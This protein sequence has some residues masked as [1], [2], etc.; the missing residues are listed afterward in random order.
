MLS[1]SNTYNEEELRDWD[2]RVRKGL[3]DTPYEYVCEIKFD[4]ISLSM[5]YENG[6]LVRGVTRGDGT[7]GD[8][9]TA[10]VKTI[11]SLPL[12]VSKTDTF[13][14][15]GE[16]FLPTTEFEKINSQLKDEGKPTLANPRNAASGTFKMQDSRVVGTRNLDCFVYQFLSE[17]DTYQTHSESLEGLRT[18]GFNVSESSKLVRNIDEAIAYIHEWDKKR[19]N[20]SCATDGIV[21]KVN[22]YSQREELGFTSK[23]PRWAIAYK[24]KAETK[25]TK[26]LGVTY[27]VGRT[28]AITPVAELEPV[29]LSMTTVRRATLHNADEMQRLGLII[30]DYVWVEKAGEIIPKITHVEM[31]KRTPQMFAETLTFVTN[32]PACNAPLERSEGEAAWYCPNEKSCPPQISGRIE[33]FIQ[34]KALDIDSLGQG[35]IEIL[36]ENG[37]VKDPADLYQ[38]TYDNLLGLEKVHIDTETGKTRK[39]SFKEKTVENI[40]NGIEKSKNQPFE[41]VL[42]G[43]GIRFAG[44]TT[45]EKLASY[46]KNIDD[47]AKATEEQLLQVPDV[48]EKVAQSIVAYFSDEDNVQLIN[49]L[50]EAG[51]QLEIVERETINEGNALVGMLLLY[52]GTFKKYS[53]QELED[54]IAANGGK[55]VSGVSK[56]LNYLIVGE[57]AGPSKVAKAEKLGVPMISEEEFEALIA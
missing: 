25:T 55:L 28:G 34:R 33:H 22:S 10:N 14:I 35:K 13:E 53:R 16:G 17:N 5:T 54:K 15:R 48:G 9:I 23:S 11:R 29:E 37:L 41:M 47:L 46:F 51:L 7:K 20:L 31:S 24:Y 12:K 18:L 32:C 44:Q 30:G 52:T 6:Y 40:L 36:I 3:L 38:L 49:K 57:G 4:G 42:F 1:L 43:L 27:Q 19:H 2:E 39:V 50:K 8:D 21:I 56:K 45:T 26:L